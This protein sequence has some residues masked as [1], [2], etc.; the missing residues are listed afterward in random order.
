M[1]S[2]APPKYP[3]RPAFYA[4]RYCRLLFLTRA[5]SE[6]GP[7]AGLICIDVA[8]TE[9]A[10]RYTG[11][12][13]FYAQDLAARCGVSVSTMERARKRAV[14]AGW[15]HYEPGAKR[16]PATYWTTIPEQV[17]D[18]PDGLTREDAGDFLRQ[19]DGASGEHPGSIGGRTD[20]P[21]TL[22]LS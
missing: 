17:R 18:V 20:G 11:P 4:H 7:E 22:A 5:A 6:I 15:L 21:S 2:P 3:Q 13:R 1:S 14:D 8:H 19:P 9:D 12:V 16:R 10:T